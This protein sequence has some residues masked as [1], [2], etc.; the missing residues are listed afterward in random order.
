MAAERHS[1]LTAS[2]MTIQSDSETYG[3]NEL[4]SSP[5]SSSSSPIILYKP[6]TILSLVRSTA[7][8]LILPFMNGLMMGFGELFAHEIAFRLGWSGTKVLPSGRTQRPMGAGVEIRSDPIEAERRK[9]N[10]QDMT[11]LE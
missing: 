11:S 2:S 5:P 3:N 8:N 4:S 7:I 10:L 6:P 9:G 1:D